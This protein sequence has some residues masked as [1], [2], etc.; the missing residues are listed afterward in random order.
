[1][2]VSWQSWKGSTLLLRIGRVLGLDTLGRTLTCDPV[3]RGAALSHPYICKGSHS[4]YAVGPST[5]HTWGSV[6]LAICGAAS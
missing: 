5:E 4:G 6:M 3:F 2:L 1:M